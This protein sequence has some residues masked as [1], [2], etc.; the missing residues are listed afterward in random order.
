MDAQ[1]PAHQPGAW[2]RSTVMVTEDTC[3]TRVTDEELALVDA[4]SE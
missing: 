4:L 1:R 3:F 2:N